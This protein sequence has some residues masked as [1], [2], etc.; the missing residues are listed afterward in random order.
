[1]GGFYTLT[2]QL[3]QYIIEMFNLFFVHF[4]PNMIG[5]DFFEKS[6]SENF[7]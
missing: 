1:M 2:F 4:N 3:N 7:T 5:G 6:T